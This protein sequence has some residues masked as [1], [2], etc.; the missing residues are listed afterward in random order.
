MKILMIGLYNLNYY[1]RGKVIYMGLLK[2]NIETEVFAPTKFKI[3]SLVKRILKKDYD[4]LIVTGK[5]AFWTSKLL[6]FL[7]RKKIIFDVFISD[8]D[9]LVI[10]RKTVKK[11]SL[12]AKLLWLSDKYSCKLSDVVIHDT[13]EHIAYFVKEFCLKKSLFNEV[14][15]GSDDSMFYP[16]E[17]PQ[18]KE[19]IVSFYG[20]FIPVHGVEYILGAA[21]LLEHENIVFELTG[22]GQTYEDMIKLKEK[23]R[24]K[25]ANFLGPVP[26]EKLPERIA[27]GD[28]CLGIFGNTPRALRVIPTKAFD[29]IAMKKPLVSADS[30]TMRR[31]FSHKKNVYLCKVADA[32]SL[33]GA[34]IALKNKKLRDKIAEG[35]YKLYRE[36]ASPEI[37][38]RQVLKITKRLIN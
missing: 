20:T 11:G 12:F 18:T 21:K 31:V 34:I 35:G 38:G 13:K 25:N 29:I 17:K 23:L 16:I 14:F 30:P 5:P 1:P 19:F 37:I 32:K 28:V 24:L 6:Q 26:I 22:K 36:C 7:H 10:D 9:N 15:V 8:Y 2:S 4:I 33:A 27:R 3:F